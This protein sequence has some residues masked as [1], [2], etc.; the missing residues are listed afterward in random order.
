[1][2]AALPE[3]AAVPD[4]GSAMATALFVT[5]VGDCPAADAVTNATDVNASATDAMKDGRGIDT[6]DLHPD[7][8][9]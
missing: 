1:M 4:L 6:L 7:A 8:L 2:F 3:F 9:S 5:A